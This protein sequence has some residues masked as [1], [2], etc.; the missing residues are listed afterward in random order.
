[1][2]GCDYMA[3][4]KSKIII[5]AD[6]WKQFKEMD[7]ET[8]GKLFKIILSY[9]NDEHPE[10]KLPKGDLMRLLFIPYK[11]TLDRDL[12][13]YKDKCLKNSK[14]SK[15]RWNKNECESMQTD[16]NACDRK[17]RNANYADTD[18]DSDTDSDSDTDNDSNI[19][20]DI[21]LTINNIASEF[22]MSD[23]WIRQMNAF[24]YTNH[25]DVKYPKKFV[26]TYMENHPEIQSVDEH[27]K[28]ILENIYRRA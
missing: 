24:I 11:T 14:N 6:W 2:I 7:D 19:K 12:E 15:K 10:E 16:A 3:N 26:K 21:I 27:K 1:M 8:A 9:V 20:E 4:G 23:E 5:Y 13:A 25:I 22:G 18:N 28:E 17:N